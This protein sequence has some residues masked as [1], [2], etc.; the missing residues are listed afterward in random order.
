MLLFIGFICA[1]IALLTSGVTG[2]I[3][4]QIS[5]ASPHKH[6]AEKVSRFVPLEVT[7][8]WVTDLTNC[9]AVATGDSTFTILCSAKRFSHYTSEIV[10]TVA[11]PTS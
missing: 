6:V 8:V 3:I 7:V 10:T 5:W 9:S 11:K 2:N 4:G 1:P